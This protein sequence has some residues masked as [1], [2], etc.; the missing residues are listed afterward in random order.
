M[1]TGVGGWVVCIRRCSGMVEG[2][3]LGGAWIRCVGR[4]RDE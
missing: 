1:T 3:V 4:A 2:D